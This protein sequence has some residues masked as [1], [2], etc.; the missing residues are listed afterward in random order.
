MRISII[1]LLLSFSSI[2]AQEQEP[3][4]YSE[5]YDKYSPRT[6]YLV[7][8]GKPSSILVNDTIILRNSEKWIEHNVYTFEKPNEILVKKYRNDSLAKDE[9]YNLDSKKRI[10]KYEGNIKYS[11]GEWY[12]TRLNF[13]YE[14][15][16]KITEKINRFGKIYMRYEVKYDSLKNPILIKSTIVG[17]PNSSRLENINYDYK[18]RIFARS[19]FN[20]NGKIRNEEEGFFNTDYVINRNPNNDITKMYWITSNKNDKIIYDIEYEYDN[21]GNWIKMIKSFSEG[22]EPKK[23]YSKTYR[24][25]KYKN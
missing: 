3:D 9:K 11:K 20:F 19:E 24:E 25:I 14:P 7:K 13:S 16:K 15:N 12:I 4:F 10:I 2:K 23:I 17:G 1:I 5:I 8:K 18:N 21:Y 6:H 22:E